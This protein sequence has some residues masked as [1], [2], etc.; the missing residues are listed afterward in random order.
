MKHE[1]RVF[2]MASQMCIIMFGKQKKRRGMMIAKSKMCAICRC[3]DAGKK[4]ARFR[5]PKTN[6][7]EGLATPVSTKCKINWAVSIFKEWQLGKGASSGFCRTVQGLRT[8]E[9]ERQIS[10]K[11]RLL[12]CVIRRHF[13]LQNGPEALNPFD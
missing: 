3:R 12:V 8:E 5:D 6:D 11:N 2:D 13:E 10:A 9:V 7:E 1:A 4:R